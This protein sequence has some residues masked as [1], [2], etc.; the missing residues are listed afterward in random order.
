MLFNFDLD[1]HGFIWI[2]LISIILEGARVEYQANQNIN[3]WK[4]R[5]YTQRNR[6]CIIPP[7]LP[8]F[9]QSMM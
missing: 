3:Q 6:K 8:T 9:I 4:E 7:L 2:V 1:I 5:A